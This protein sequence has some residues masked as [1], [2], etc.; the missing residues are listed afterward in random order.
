LTEGEEHDEPFLVLASDGLWDVL[1]NQE[2]ARLTRKVCRLG[3]PVLPPP[4]LIVR[5]KPLRSGFVSWLD[6]T[7]SY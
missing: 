3:S 4:L 7:T 6:F 1:S 2:V 5:W